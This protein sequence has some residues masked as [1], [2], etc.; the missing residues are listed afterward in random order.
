M[1]WT[2][3]RMRSSSSTWAS[4]AAIPPESFPP[5]RSSWTHHAGR[6][7]RGI[8]E[9]IW[10]GRRPE[11]LLE[12][13]LHE[14][15]L[16]V[17]VDPEVPFWLICPYDAGAARR[18]RR[19]GGPSQSPGDRRGRLLRRAASATAVARTSTRCSAPI[20]RSTR[21]TDHDHLR[22]RQRGA[23]GGLPPAGAVRRRADGGSRL[24]SWPRRATGWP[25]A[26][27]TAARPTAPSGSGT[28]PTRYLRRLR[29]DRRRR[30]APR[31]ADRRSAT[32]TTD[33]GWPTRYAIWSRC[34][35]R[36]T[37]PRCACTPGADSAPNLNVARYPPFGM[38]IEQRGGDR[39]TLMVRPSGAL[40]PASTPTPAP[41]T[42]CR[43]EPAA[44]VGQ[45]LVQGSHLLRRRR[46]SPCRP[47][48]SG[49]RPP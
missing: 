10:P 28:L 18:R 45:R 12:C 32:T 1:P 15:L 9:P 49:R 46:R 39:A 38:H 8:G 11:E 35:R 4:W 34:G 48:S 42:R 3:R 29:R 7:V 40:S 33:S 6:P 43:V 44:E 14:A 22:R 24:R 20:C 21:R 41:W 31:P 5:G 36:R 17:A 30:P 37:A 26:A 47:R 13:Q 27:C 2:G 23:A 16:N 25:S 19:R